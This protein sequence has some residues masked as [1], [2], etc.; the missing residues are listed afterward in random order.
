M[1]FPN[2]QTGLNLP[3]EIE[4]RSIAEVKEALAIGGFQ[5]IMFDNFSKTM[6]RIRIQVI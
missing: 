6:I 4:T 2:F 1:H 3:I 5:R